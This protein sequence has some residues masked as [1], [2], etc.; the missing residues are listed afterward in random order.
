MSKQEQ[1]VKRLL[2][3]LRRDGKEGLTAKAIRR[4]AL[5]ADKNYPCGPRNGEQ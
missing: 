4:Q 2:T 1:E 5:A 3:A